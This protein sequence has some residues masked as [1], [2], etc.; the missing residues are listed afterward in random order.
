[1]ADGISFDFSALNT[2]AAELG[3]AATKVVP[4]VR[5]AVEVTAHNIKE[6]WRDN[7]KRANPGHAKNYPAAIDYDLEL[8]VDGAIG[9]EIGPTPG[10]GQG[11]LGI[12]EEAKGG[13]RSAPQGNARKALKSNIADFE[14]GI[15]KATEGLL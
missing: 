14:R 8:G 2:L 12:L 4:N 3:A 13:V 10:K 15:L 1:M 11:S 7:A 6:D 9:A 5:K